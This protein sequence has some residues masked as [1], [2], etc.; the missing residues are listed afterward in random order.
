MN[1]ELKTKLVFASLL[2]GFSTMASAT[3]IQIQTAQT[4]N[5]VVSPV[6]QEVVVSKAAQKAIDTKVL[7]A[8]ARPPVFVQENGPTFVQS[9]FEQMRLP[10]VPTTPA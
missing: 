7:E 10:L 2:A 5:P 3:P 6:R 8:V 9:K 1:T 4:E